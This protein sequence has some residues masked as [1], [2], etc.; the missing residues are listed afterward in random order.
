MT[1][2]QS[3]EFLQW[4]LPRLRLRWPGFRKVRR[5]VRK[6]INRRLGELGL[7]DV[8]DY[9]SYLES[10]P[11]EWSVLDAFCRI[12]ISRFYR[13]R[14]VFDH[15]G[16]RLLPELARTAAAR[17][18]NEL[19]VWCAGCASGEEAYTLAI[20]WNTC[21]LPDFPR[22]RLRQVATDV[23]EQMLG[24]A[25]RACYMASS[26][27]DAPP[28]WLGSAFTRSGKEYLLHRELCAQVEFLQQDIRAELPDGPFHLVLCRN[29]VFTYFDEDLQREILRRIAERVVADGLLVIGKQE[30][31]PVG[32]EGVSPCNPNLRIYRISA[33]GP[34]NDPQLQRQTI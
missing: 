32:V 27:K 28:D 31:L 3:V 4:A 29:L 21:L 20:L 8:S 33:A 1:D 15:L 30:S 2:Q 14:G 10:H 12:P 25:R 22:M 17:R 19:C 16:R 26:L 7:S 9:R 18:E 24:R 13:D 6:R 34:R 11:A 23:D 5:Q